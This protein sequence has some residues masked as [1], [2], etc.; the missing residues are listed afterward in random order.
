MKS[1]SEENVADV[2]L[3][4][5]Y[6]RIIIVDFYDYFEL[7]SKAVC[8]SFPP[9]RLR[10]RQGKVS[11]NGGKMSGRKAPQLYLLVDAREL[12]QFRCLRTSPSDVLSMISITM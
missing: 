7:L 1:S 5:V 3:K 10:F 6:K 11:F 4:P 8:E 9:H 2:N 12:I